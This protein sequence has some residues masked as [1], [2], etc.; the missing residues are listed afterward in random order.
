[1]RTRFSKDHDPDCLALRTGLCRFGL[2]LLDKTQAAH[3][4]VRRQSL[5]MNVLPGLSMMAPE[6]LGLGCRTTLAGA[7]PMLPIILAYTTFGYW[8][9][10]RRTS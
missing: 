5:A 10:R 8:V 6:P 4:C 3:E 9:F 1:V 7:A 2:Y